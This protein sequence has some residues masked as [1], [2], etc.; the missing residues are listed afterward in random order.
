MR[1]PDLSDRETSGDAAIPDRTVVFGLAGS[2]RMF[3]DLVLRTIETAFLGVETMRCPDL[4]TWSLILNDRDS[5]DRLPLRLLIVDEREVADL[6]LYLRR[7]DPLVRG[8]NLAIA[9]RE[10]RSAIDL[11]ARFGPLFARHRISVLPMNLNLNAWIQLIRLIDCGAHYLPASVYVAAHAEAEDDLPEFAIPCPMAE[12]A[13]GT[14]CT[15]GLKALTPRER[16]VLKLVAAGR[17]NKV[18]A[19][20]LSVSAHTVKLHIHRIMAKLGATNR[21]EA[22]AC[23]HHCNG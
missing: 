14:R 6:V 7:D 20:D 15:L 17:P 4:P 23:F 11:L 3:S 1:E 9:V 8:I 13:A 5:G 18:I 12:D 2:S 19:N 10:D 21:T 22:A 16:E